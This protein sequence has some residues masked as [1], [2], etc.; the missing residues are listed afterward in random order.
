MKFISSTKITLLILKIA[1]FF[2]ILWMGWKQLRKISP[3]DWNA[4]SISQ[5]LAL[6]ACFGLLFFNWFFEFLK[7][8]TI[9]RIS[10]ISADFSVQLK[11]FLA[12]ILTGF[13]T[14]NL[15]GNFIGR[16]FYFHR[17]NRP[18]IIIF[19]FFSNGAQFL[20]SMLFG[21]V[22]LFWMGLHDSTWESYFY[23]I[24]LAS[25]LSVILFLLLF[26]QFE[27]SQWKFIQ[28]NR[29][30]K[31][32]LPFLQHSNSFRIKLLLLSLFRHGVFSFQ[33]WLMLAAFGLNPPLEW[34]GWI[35]QLFFWSTLIPSLWLGK[36]VIRE[37]MAI[38]V[39]GTI[40]GNPAA[41][42]L[43]SVTLWGINQGIPAMLGIPFLGKQK[44]EAV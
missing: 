25:S 18:A 5:P 27:E 32:V 39:L 44:N 21:V 43:A 40:S 3:S 38:W 19:T 28:E 37:S 26:F 29:F 30:L 8:K 2:F 14:P 36:L 42:L 9:L 35:W 11:S 4:I 33:Y 41:V 34:L 22:G 23:Y 1:L 6:L 16:M 10:Q 15:L 13:L 7:W 20:A 17:R 12:G 24:L 31:R